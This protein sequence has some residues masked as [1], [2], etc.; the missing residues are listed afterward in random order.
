MQNSFTD[1]NTTKTV[2]KTKVNKEKDIR[3]DKNKDY[4]YF[5]NK[6][7]VAHDLDIEYQDIILNFEDKENIQNKLNDETKQ[8]KE[9]LEFDE[10]MEDPDFDNVVSATYKTYEYYIYE[11]YIS[12]VVNYYTFDRE[13]LISFE[14]T[15]TYV[16]DR[17]TG[18]RLS[19]EDILASFDLTE[20]D[21]FNK[22]EEHLDG[23]NLLTEVEIDTDATIDAIEDL[24]IYVDRL[25]RL[26]MSILVINDQKG[27]NE[28][29]LLN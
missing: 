25:G 13:N 17:Q 27:Y 2:Y 23:Q 10:E 11:D 7:T 26:S 21:V 24:A 20:D 19:E 16:F 14:D 6:E 9:A 22:I 8:Y 1:N 5:E 29:V 15:D 18:L 4:I 3:K 28:V 12:L